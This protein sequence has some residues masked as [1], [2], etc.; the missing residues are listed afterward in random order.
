VVPF[1]PPPR[2]DDA[3]GGY[4]EF[5]LRFWR[6]LAVCREAGLKVTVKSLDNYLWSVPKAG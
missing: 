1:D 5:C 3:P 2:S 4:Y 6:L